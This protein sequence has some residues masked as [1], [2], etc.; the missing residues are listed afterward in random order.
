MAPYAPEWMSN[1]RDPRRPPPLAHIRSPHN[2]HR[3]SRPY[4]DGDLRP[5]H[6]D[7]DHAVEVHIVRDIIDDH[8]DHPININFNYGPVHIHQNCLCPNPSAHTC[9]PATA[10]S[11]RRNTTT[12]IT[13]PYPPLPGP[14]PPPPPAAGAPTRRRPS[15]PPLQ[16]LGHS[17]PRPYHP[18]PAG[19]P[20]R[21]A[22]ARSVTR[23]IVPS[24]ESGYSSSSSSALDEPP[25]RR[26]R[27]GS[28]RPR[29][30]ILRTDRSTGRGEVGPG[31]GVTVTTT[32][33]SSSS[34]AAAGAIPAAH[35]GGQI[36]VQVGIC[37]GC[38]TRRRLVWGGYCAECEVFVDSGGDDVDEDEISLSSPGPV[39]PRIWARARSPGPGTG[40]ALRRGGGHGGALRVRYV[41]G[42]RE[43][44]APADR[45]GMRG[46]E[47]LER[48]RESDFQ[49][50]ERE[51]MERNR[52]R[53]D[54]ERD[55]V[56]NGVRRGVRWDA[57]VEARD[58][59]RDRRSYPR[60]TE[61]VYF[62]ESEGDSAW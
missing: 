39:S 49:R 5:D 23:I 6:H 10:A 26:H 3:R 22:S 61:R 8:P 56:R 13:Y 43:D 47:L 59:G 20:P 12:G 45:R 24:P 44:S 41:S 17:A 1:I 31:G 54:R 57:D 62:S 15:R 35:G 19:S 27:S 2:L 16:P 34:A 32:S 11:G 51:A 33:S 53:R 29:R 28:P 4:R 55:A 38:L 25:P 37:D 21:H 46:R 40:T 52:L 48:E 36:R 58:R 50:E 42:G 9:S 60:T 7:Q 30:G 18:R 14:P